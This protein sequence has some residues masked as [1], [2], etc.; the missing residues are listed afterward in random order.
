M[1]TGY[2]RSGSD[3]RTNDS[4]E[5]LQDNVDLRA[6][7]VC[8]Q[9]RE[10][11]SRLFYGEQTFNLSDPQLCK[12]WFKHIGI[13]NLS[14]IRS[15]SLVLRSGFQ[16][17]KPSGYNVG[18]DD[19]YEVLAPEVRNSFDLSHEEY[20]YQ[21]FL[22]FLPRH[23]LREIFI[24]LDGWPKVE[25]RTQ[26]S[27]LEHETNELKR[28]R[29]EKEQGCQEEILDWRRKLV[30]TLQRYRGLW[31]ATIRDPDQGF[32]GPRDCSNIEMMMIQHR[33]P[34]FSPGH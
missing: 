33:V 11:G 16:I 15:L 1:L 4:T 17:L 22:W 13:H 18:L 21:F 8:K 32:L 12:W 29:Q 25:M 7:Q 19:R 23:R 34:T 6:M 10:I 27:S 3:S 28:A 26:N 31:K 5:V 2:V 24:T 20:W 14:G 9:F 30:G